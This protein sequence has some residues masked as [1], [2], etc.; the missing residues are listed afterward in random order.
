MSKIKLIATDLDGTLLDSESRVPKEFFEIAPRLRAKGIHIVIASG[1][2]LF[3]IQKLFPSIENELIYI[4]DNSLFVDFYGEQIISKNFTLEQTQRILADVQ[5]IPTARLI[6]CCAESG[7]GCPCEPEF[8]AFAR[9][10]YEKLVF[11][12]AAFDAACKKGVFKFAIGDMESSREHSFPV[13]KKYQH[14]MNVVVSAPRW[15]DIMPLGIDK[16]NGI[17]LIQQRLGISPDEC[18]AF[19]DYENDLGLLRA[20]TESYAVENAMPSIKAVCKHTTDS[21][22]AGGVLKILK[23][24]L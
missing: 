18:M 22:D 11:D 4:A 13:F 6:V 15:L 3:N 9:N 1:R 7:Y 16:G 10:F 23:T 5:T 21:N 2:Q 17:S 14:E 24:L 8:E 19:G 20:C 12:D